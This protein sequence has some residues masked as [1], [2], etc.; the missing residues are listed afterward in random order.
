MSLLRSLNSGK[1]PQ[2][3]LCSRV[4]ASLEHDLQLTDTLWTDLAEQ[5]A[6]F[7]KN[8]FLSFMYW[9]EF[10]LGPIKQHRKEISESGDRR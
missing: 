6:R 8:F 7:L 10:I 4:S 9:S 3:L 2:P 1:Q 5:G